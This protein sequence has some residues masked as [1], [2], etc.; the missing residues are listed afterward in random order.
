MEKRDYQPSLLWVKT[1]N[2]YESQSENKELAHRPLGAH[3]LTLYIY[4]TDKSGAWMMH[5]PKLYW[6]DEPMS[7]QYFRNTD[8]SDLYDNADVLGEVVLW[9][10]RTRQTVLVGHTF[11]GAIA[12][13][14]GKE[15]L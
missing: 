11:E 13:I 4:R 3:D 7:G 6:T 10:R 12:K 5:G 9:D 8:Q 15:A 2:W 1:R 14:S